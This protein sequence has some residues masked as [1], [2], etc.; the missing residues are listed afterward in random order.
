MT[1]LVMVSR[2]DYIPPSLLQSCADTFSILNSHTWQTC[3]SPK[4]FFHQYSN[5]HSSRNFRKNLAY[6]NPTLQ[7]F[8]LYWSHVRTLFPSSILI[9]QT[10]LTPKPIFHQNFKLALISPLPKKTW[11]YQNPT[12]QIFDLYFEH[13]WQNVTAARS[14]SSFSSHFHIS[15]FLPFA[16]SLL[17]ISFHWDHS[18]Q[19]YIW[20][21]GNH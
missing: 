12:F 14:S 5:W 7:I 4:P 15:Q 6:H 10:S 2:F 11:L 17:Q 9:W 8:D 18:A 1:P 16:V 13:C 21:N 3:L 20:Y 19:T